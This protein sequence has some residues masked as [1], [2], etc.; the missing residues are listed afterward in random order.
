[1]SQ[2]PNFQLSTSWQADYPIFQSKANMN[3][4]VD[5][6]YSAVT[7]TVRAVLPPVAKR[8]CTRLGG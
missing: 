6:T 2:H 1:M 5:S 4:H 7:Q 8:P 3:G